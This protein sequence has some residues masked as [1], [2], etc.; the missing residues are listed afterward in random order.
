VS[1]G[2]KHNNFRQCGSCG[3]DV[4]G[5]QVHAFCAANCSMDSFVKKAF[6]WTA[7]TTQKGHIQLMSHSLTTYDLYC[8]L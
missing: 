3:L 4:R 7:L 2:A 1:A 6:P 8:L 5:V